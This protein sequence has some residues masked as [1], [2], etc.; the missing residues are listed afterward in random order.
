MIIEATEIVKNKE[1]N[2]NYKYI[3]IDEYQDISKS[4]FDLIK[5]IKNQTNAKLICVGDDWQSIYRF[6]G[7]DVDLFT[8]FD[9]HVGYYELLK[10]EKTYR[11]SQ[12]LIDISGKFI[13]K[14][15]N[16]LVKNLKSDKNNK[17]PIKMISYNNDICAAIEIAIKDIVKIWGRVAEIIILGRNNFDI[18][19]LDNSLRY[20]AINDGNDIFVK[21]KEYPQLKIKYLTVHKSKGLEGDNVIIINLEN[22]ITGFP[23]K[24]VDDQVLELVLT[25]ADNFELAEERRLFYVAL[26]RTKNTAYLIVPDKNS[27][28]FCDELKKEFDINHEEKLDEVKTEIP[29]CPRCIDGRLV[30]RISMYKKEFVGCDN[31]PMCDFTHSSIDI[32]NNTS[33][34][35]KCGSYMIKKT[36]RGI[37]FL[38]CI[39]FP[40]CKNTEVYKNINL[41][42]ENKEEK[43]NLADKFE[44]IYEEYYQDIIK[45]DYD[46]VLHNLTQIYPDIDEFL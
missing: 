37:N 14:N 21:H 17:N 20:K 39:N 16:Q 2:L 43:D 36:S 29:R 15:K 5:Q 42:N 34:C 45:S 33:I 13:M 10:I 9:K 44:H 11:N 35:N 8:N 6:T 1:I 25:K 24:M 7:S 30:K 32:L 22:K 4:R 23:N 26:T 41:I 27:S 31:Y 46:T 28:V 3:I 19:A 40:Y 12:Q 38:A 18:K